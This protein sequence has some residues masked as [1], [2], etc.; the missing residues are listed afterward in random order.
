[1]VEFN[2]TSGHSLKNTRVWVNFVNS[3]PN[4]VF[5]KQG[6]INTALEQYNGSYVFGNSSSVQF[7][8]E[9]DLLAFILKF[10]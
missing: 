8:T 3:L 1:M 6:W 4:D 2:M 7:E 9:A 10:N 5:E